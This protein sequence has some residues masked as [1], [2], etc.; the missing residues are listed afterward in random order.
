MSTD[1]TSAPAARNAAVELPVR[2]PS[3]M[4]VLPSC[5]FS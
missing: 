1:H 3:S 5:A 4:T 2:T